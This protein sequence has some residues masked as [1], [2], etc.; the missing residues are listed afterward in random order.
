MNSTAIRIQVSLKIWPG[1]GSHETK[2]KP[3]KIIHKNIYVTSPEIHSHMGLF[4]S[5]P[6]MLSMK[7]NIIQI[8]NC[9]IWMNYPA[10]HIHI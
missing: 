3:N 4:I 2:H 10:I 7:R 9:R 5:V 8:C 6:R 1:I